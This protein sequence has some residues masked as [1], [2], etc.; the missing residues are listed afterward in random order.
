VGK[1][2]G[3]MKPG[4]RNQEFLSA[5][6]VE[7]PLRLQT[8]PNLLKKANPKGCLLCEIRA[9]GIVNLLGGFSESQGRESSRVVIRVG[10]GGESE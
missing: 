10:V 9:R 8:K 4:N 6:W 5:I 1:G 3:S 2:L 7:A